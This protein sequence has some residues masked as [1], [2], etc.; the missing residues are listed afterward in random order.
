MDILQGILEYLKT[1][2]SQWGVV[3]SWLLYV[4]GHP[5]WVLVAIL[6]WTLLSKAWEGAKG[7]VATGPKWWKPLFWTVFVT[8]LFLFATGMA[9]RYVPVLGNWYI[10]Q[11]H[12]GAVE[13]KPI[14]PP[15]DGETLNSPTA[16]PAPTSTGASDAVPTNAAAV[17]ASNACYKITDPT[18][19]TA[20]T[21]PNST[22]ASAGD[23][24]IDAG[25][26]VRVS[27]TVDSNTVN[28]VSKRAKLAEAA[29]GVPAGAWFH[30]AAAQA[31]A[32]P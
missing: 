22:S 10:Q 24:S 5:W 12:D 20:R 30:L 18:G 15:R 31:T 17:T 4:I 23:G 28:G 13:V 7:W 14:E 32:C 1:M 25:L 26:V 16:V 2:L 21:E 6:G 3:G 19:A 9:F 11:L 29:G 8:G 27:E